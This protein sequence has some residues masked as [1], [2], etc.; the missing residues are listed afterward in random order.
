MYAIRS[1]YELSAQGI[2][3][4]VVISHL[5]D[6]NEE[7][8]LVATLKDV[9]VV[10][11]GGGDELLGNES[12]ATFPG[13]GAFYDKYPIVVKDSED[14]NVYLVT[15]PGEYKYVGRLD[16]NF[17]ENGYVTQVSDQSGLYLVRPDECGFDAALRVNAEQPVKDA[18]DA[19][20][21]NVIANSEVDLDGTRSSIRAI[22][23]NRNNFV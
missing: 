5:Q 11:A 16:L 2:N 13:D 12:T 6:I 21:S 15:T 4:I 23:T 1:Y 19:Y 22:E 10:I 9:D 8:Q 20:E 18:L 3:K 7:K 14:K 17:D